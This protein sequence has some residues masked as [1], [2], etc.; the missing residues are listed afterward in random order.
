MKR[1]ALFAPLVGLTLA[2]CSSSEPLGEAATPIIGG[3]VDQGDPAIVL[4]VSIPPDHSFF[5]TCTASL[6][7]PTVLLTAAHCLDPKTHA[8]YA[9][10]VFSGADASAYPTAAALGPQ[11]L[12]V[13]S[14]HMHPDYDD[15]PPFHADLGVALLEEA[16]E[17]TPL[18][19][20]RSAPAP[21]IVGG[22]ARIVGYGQTKYGE[23]N[24][25]K[26]EASTVVAAIGDED[27]IVVGDGERRGCVGDSGGPALVKVDGV[28]QIVGV[29]SYTETTGCLEPA[30]YR[31]AD[32]YASFLDTYA[33]P[34]VVDAG[35]DASSGATGGASDPGTSGGCAIAGNA[36]GGGGALA[37]LFL[38]A[39]AL[40]RR[41]R[42]RRRALS[43]IVVALAALS[44]GCGGT[45]RAHLLELHVSGHV[46]H[47]PQEEVI[48][49]ATRILGERGFRVP[50]ASEGVI[51]T[52]WRG[53]LE[54]EEFATAYERYVIQIKRLTKEHCRV[55]A[56]KLTYA[57]VGMETYHP[58]SSYKRDGS[59]R[60]VNTVNN[61]K[62]W[63]GLTMGAPGYGRDF[64]FEWLLLR[65]VEPARARL[66]EGTVDWEMKRSGR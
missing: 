39:V 9:F 30:H 43:L 22:P 19:I 4:L 2:G 36:R 65:Q 13:K 45:S 37:A 26:H 5:D 53:I 11:L 20:A 10:G 3:T 57:S 25:V 66:L 14:V 60:T 6:I 18:P 29:D 32:V 27:T 24:A 63:Q 61:G 46:Y 42:A 51:R 33:P 7:A 50:P 28:E 16:L 52:D 12:A 8:G 54:D 34:P 41:T 40:L 58:T 21:A 64:D 44:I 56:V 62:G 55:Q 38:G 47:H 35:V 48:A 17:V 23:Y 59:G 1:I 49:A 31:R 15:A